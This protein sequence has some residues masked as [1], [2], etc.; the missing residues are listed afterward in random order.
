MDNE[1][2]L[3]EDLLGLE[4]ESC[5]EV[6]TEM[7]STSPEPEPLNFHEMFVRQSRS[8]EPNYYRSFHAVC[9]GVLQKKTRNLTYSQKFFVLTPCRL[10]YYDNQLCERLGGCFNLVALGA[11]ELTRKGLEIR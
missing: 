4:G 6:G 2:A 7:E 5:L 8:E 1:S 3:S 9:A 10:L 11:T